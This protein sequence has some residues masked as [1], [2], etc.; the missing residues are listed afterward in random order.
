MN[1][2]YFIAGSLHFIPSILPLI[3]E[4]GGVIITFK[5][6]VEKLIDGKEKNYTI[7]YYRNNKDLLKDFHNLKIDVLVHPSFSVQ[8]FKKFSGIK[9]VQIFHGISDK[10]FSFHK[11]LKYYDLITV[12]G[13]KKK[14]DIIK[15]G[16]ARQDKIAVIGYPK[17]DFF[18]NSHF[19]SEA[20]KNKIE[21]DPS[22]RI[23]LYSPTWVDRNKVS[24]FSKYVVSVLRNLR[25]F[26]VIVKPHP[27]ILR[28]RPWQILKAYVMK[29]KNCFIYPGSLNVLP[30]M[31][32]SDIL[33]TDISAVAQEYL[34]FDR[35]IIFLHPKPGSDIPPERTWI[36]R[37]G[38]VVV[39]KNKILNAVK[40]NLS[41]PDKYKSQREKA[42]GFIFLE[43][44][45]K[46][47]LRFKELLLDLAVRRLPLEQT[48]Y[49]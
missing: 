33:L 24:S 14:E 36:W 18:L 44:D 8:R 28:Y 11:S 12:P 26:N 42:L 21:L 15:K 1:V 49:Q 3:M 47:A 48:S 34:P 20:F 45:G 9:H 10:P 32:V 2:G 23:V 16:L 30:F 17:L 5:K 38:D 19:D 31:A 43:F 29:R 41:S 7:S 37:C 6:G 4:T 22:R 27:D 40:E 35:P 13:L 46:S 25:D 39:D